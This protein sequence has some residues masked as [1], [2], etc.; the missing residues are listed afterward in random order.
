M[1]RTQPKVETRLRQVKDLPKGDLYVR[2]NIAF[3]AKINNDAR[4]RIIE[5][6]EKNELEL[7]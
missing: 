5:A 3:P 6:L 1:P 4:L 2:F 7:A